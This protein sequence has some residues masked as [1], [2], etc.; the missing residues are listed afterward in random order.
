MHFGLPSAFASAV[1]FSRIQISILFFPFVFRVWSYTKYCVF[2]NYEVLVVVGSGLGSTSACKRQFTIFLFIE[3]IKKIKVLHVLEPIVGNVLLV[4][5]SYFTTKLNP[6]CVR[7][8]ERTC[9]PCRD[10]R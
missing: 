8:L 6:S 5:V 7:N 10:L 9:L 1:D 2:S 3:Y 4:K